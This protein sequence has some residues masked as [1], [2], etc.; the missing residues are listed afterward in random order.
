MNNLKIIEQLES[1]NK[2]NKGRDKDLNK[3]INLLYDVE[4]LIN[5]AKLN[6][7]DD[8]SDK[9]YNRAKDELFKLLNTIKYINK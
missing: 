3:V 5:E 6:D 1:E 4:G 7:L 8:D 2:L 9:F